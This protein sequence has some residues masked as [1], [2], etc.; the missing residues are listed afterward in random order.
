MWRGIV[1][2]FLAIALTGYAQERDKRVTIT[3]PILRLLA[4][5][6]PLPKYPERAVAAGS[7]GRVVVSVSYDS[8]GAPVNMGVLDATAPDFAKAA[9]DAVRQWRFRPFV[10]QDKTIASRATGRLVFYFVREHG[11]ALVIDAAAVELAREKA[12]AGVPIQR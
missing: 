3:S 1:L 9:L 11:R 7:G 2:P 12:A 8:T 4:T 5:T 10:L 6:A